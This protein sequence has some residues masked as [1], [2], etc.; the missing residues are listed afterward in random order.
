M[1][2][3]IS[4]ASG[5]MATADLFQLFGDDRVVR[6]VDHHVEAILTSV[7]A[8][9]VSITFGNSVFGSPSTS[10]F[11][12]LAIQQLARRRSVRTASSAL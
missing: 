1:P 12:S 5:M 7:S 2:E 4:E 8:A 11:T 10:S 3:P 6:G 9:R